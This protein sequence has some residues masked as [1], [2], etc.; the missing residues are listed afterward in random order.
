M[1]VGTA[2]MF[3]TSTVAA[4]EIEG[5]FGAEVALCYQCKRCTAGCPAVDFMELR[6]HQLVRLVRLG[7][8]DR[9]ISSEAIWN[10]VGCYTCTARC[11]QNVPVAELVYS[12][13]NLALREG[14]TPRRAPVP[15]FL[16]AFG[17]TVER[18]GRSREAEML[19]RYFLST[20]PRAA[21]KQAPVGLKLMRQGRLPL[22]GHG[23]RGWKAVKRALGKARRGGGEA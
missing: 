6:P 14:K 22:W 20:D 23:V 7:A 11:P 16:R 2:L 18:H 19:A 1:S 8:A 9:S 12:L 17:S 5:R 21:L 15:A 13:K 3:E 10:C 4:R